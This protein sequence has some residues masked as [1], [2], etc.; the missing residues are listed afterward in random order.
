MILLI[1]GASH[2]GKT[3]LAQ[4]LLETY[5][6]PYLSLDH[7]KMGLIRSQYTTITPSDDEE[8]T[9][10]LWP[11]TREIIKT[12]IENEQNLIIEGYYIP[13][14]WKNDFEEEYLKN[15][16][17]ICL[18]FT[19]KY[20]RMHYEDIRKYANVI[21]KRLDDSTLSIETVIEDNRYVLEQCIKHDL[22]YILIDQEYTVKEFVL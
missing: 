17:Y 10:Y 15:I 5:H 21:E 16:R 19:E 7:L 22:A 6:Y 11:I 8:L 18:V 13:Y 9:E 12:A 2:T 3:A 14:D 20:I 4:H 1:T